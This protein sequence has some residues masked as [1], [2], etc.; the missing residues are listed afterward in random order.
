MTSE[1]LV[2]GRRSAVL[3]TVI[4]SVLAAY[5]G[6]ATA[7][8]YESEDGTRVIWNTTVT[9]GASWRAEDPHPYLYTQ[10]DGSLIGLYSGERAA[11]TG[12]PLNGVDGLAGN[13][14][15]SVGN[16]NY[17]K[18][19]RFSTPFKLITDVELKRGN[20][21]ALLRVKAWYDQALNEEKVR[22]GN[23]PNNFNGTRAQL[24]PYPLPPAPPYCVPIPPVGQATRLCVPMSAPG[25]NVWPTDKLSD[26]HFEA[27]QKFDG[28]YLLDAYIYGSLDVGGSDVQLRLGNQVINWGESLFIPGVNQFNPIDV[29][30][31]RRAG[32]EVKEILLP[33]WAAYAN[34]GFGFGSVEA[35]YQLQWNNTSV[36]G[37]ETYWATGG[38]IVS[39]SPGSCDSFTTFNNNATA[40]PGTATPLVPQFGSAV[41]GQA[42]GYYVP[43]ARGQEP[44]DSGQFGIAF[45]FPVDMI[46]TEIGLYAMNIHSRTPIASM[47]TGTGFNELTPQE[48]AVLGALGL[49]NGSAATATAYAN[50]IRTAVPLIS[51]LAAFASGGAIQLTDTVGYFEYPEDVQIYGLSAATNLFGW[52]VQGEIS[53]SADVP[54]QINGN[55]LV[56][57]M[58]TW[59][60]PNG[61][62]AAETQLTGGEGT[63]LRG[64]DAYDKTQVQLST[65]KSF[66]NILGA[67]SLALAAEVGYQAN[68]L[69]D[70]KKDGG[71]RYGRGSMHGN[72]SNP[73]LA[74]QIPP[75]QGNTC[76]VT[77]LYNPSPIG[78]KN[79][80]F[81]STDAWGYRLRASMT[82]N[83]VFNSGITVIPSVFWSQ[84]VDGYSM[85]GTFLEDRET[86]GLGLKFDYSKRYVLDLNW[87]D[88]AD[89]TYDPFF[90]RDYYSASFSVTF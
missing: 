44:Q 84:D 90:D 42:N 34:W 2:Q 51:E 4:G 39:V 63:Y 36:D 74:A 77:P 54:V 62:R 86:L 75:L 23:Q 16:L 17:D 78:C 68:S 13:H 55:D 20:F 50:N 79:D 30:A 12:V 89:E 56:N 59:L 67:E 32:A 38:S 14:A 9:V 46:D 24:G 70:Y 82:Y 43:L 83:N 37:C 69:G 49:L 81:V 52:A 72:G 7:I 58:L 47:R 15:G 48:K 80:G 25:T 88:Y 22:I 8:E 5:A 18:G 6:S 10:G 35:F 41:W 33:V 21:G 76:A 3:A 65:I 28:V 40:V 71:V 66:S 61:A 11:G 26:D 1:S 53:Y 60:G 73:E 31:A 19:D 85:D 45:R 57:S 87:V 27:E 64:Y 29:P